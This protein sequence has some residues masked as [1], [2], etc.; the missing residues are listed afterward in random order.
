MDLEIQIA[1]LERQEADIRL[2][3]KPLY[4]QRAEAQSPFQID[5]VAVDRRGRRAR[6]VKI[7]PGGWSR[8]WPLITGLRI[9][10]DGTEGQEMCLYQLDG[11]QKQQG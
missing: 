7:A 11:W 10:K 1:D 8:I 3:L 9:R 4:Q 2:K 5:D 6:V